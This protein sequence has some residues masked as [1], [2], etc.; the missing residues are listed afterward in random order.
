MGVGFEFD[1]AAVEE[2]LAEVFFEAGHDLGIVDDGIGFKVEQKR[3][4]VKIGGADG[5]EGAV[6]EQDFGVEGAFVIDV[7]LDAGFEQFLEK[8]VGGPV[9]ERLFG[10][11]LDDEADVDTAQGGRF[12]RHERAGAGD[13]VGGFDVDAFPGGGDG[14]EEELQDRFPVGV[15]AAAD[16]LDGVGADAGHVG[17]EFGTGQLFAGQEVPVVEEGA[18]EVVDAFAFEFQVG[19]AEVAEFAVARQIFVADVHSADEAYPAVDDDD[20]A[21]VAEV[22]AK[23][24][25]GGHRVEAADVDAGL[26]HVG[27]ELLVDA[28]A[29]EAVEDDADADAGAAFALENGEDVLADL[30]VFQDVVFEVDVVD[31]R[32]EGGAEVLEFVFAVGEDLDAVVGGQG[33]A[34]VLAEQ[35]GQP[36]HGGREVV[37]GSGGGFGSGG[38]A[39]A[40]VAAEDQ[41]DEVADDGK[42]GK[43]PQPKG[44][45]GGRVVFEEEGAAFQEVEEENQHEEFCHMGSPVVVSVW[46]LCR[47]KRAGKLFTVF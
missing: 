38:V 43:D 33:A 2:V 4:D 46:A 20:F 9:G 44:G 7:D 11:P 6:D 13:E 30:V 28:A 26:F 14:E 25:G 8:G 34:G 15:G 32:F 23:Q 21:V 27:E 18:L 10:Q 17:K 1:G 12:Q 19:V 37:G 39:G 36:L 47:V 42:Q 3:A 31:G 22:E 41:V 5:A 29:A 16:D 40:D 45:F 24:E 35:A